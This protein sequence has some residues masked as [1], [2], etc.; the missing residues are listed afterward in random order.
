M[1]RHRQRYRYWNVQCGEGVIN[2]I[3]KR[4]PRTE[5]CGTPAKMLCFSEVDFPMR[6]S[7]LRSRR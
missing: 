5:P 4:G 2:S 3:N 1:L 7:C 6:T